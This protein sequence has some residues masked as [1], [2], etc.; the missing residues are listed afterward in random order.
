MC[1][2]H[3]CFN[4][5]TA[6]LVFQIPLFHNFTCHIASPLIFHLSCLLKTNTLIRNGEGLVPGLQFLWKVW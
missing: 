5:T 1:I 3:N 2:R 6:V 4:Q